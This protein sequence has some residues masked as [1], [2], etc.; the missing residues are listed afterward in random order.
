MF[1]AVSADQFA[2]HTHRRKDHDVDRR[3]GIKPEEMLHENWI[4][5]Q[6]RI[7]NPHTEELFSRDKQERDREHWGCQNL[8]D[9]RGIERPE[10]QRH[11][12]PVHP[13]WPKRM[14]RGD[15]VDAGED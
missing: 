9:A 10:Q 13:L 1:A 15:E 4:A 2:D 3:V 11:S 8:N 12:E 5:A 7:E 6:T 14:K